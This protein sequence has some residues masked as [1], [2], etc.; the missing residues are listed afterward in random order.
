[1]KQKYFLLF[2]CIPVVSILFGVTSFLS[3]K[4]LTKS[5]FS[6]VAANPKNLIDISKL[7][8]SDYDNIFIEDYGAVFV[9]KNNSPKQIYFDDKQLQSLALSPS[10]QQVAF[11]YDPNETDESKEDELSLMILD[12]VNKSTKEIFHTTFPSWDVTSKPQWLGDKY[13]FFLRHCGTGCQ[14]VT[15]LNIETGQTK[16]AV[17]SYP[18]FPAQQAVTYFE[19]WFGQTYQFKDFV[20]NMHSEMIAGKFY[21][22][23]DLMDKKGME[24]GQKKFLFTGKSLILES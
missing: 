19:D 20:Q 24:S 5:P 17:L 3:Q 11:S 4:S 14:G 13:I 23:F 2:C 6:L 22:I 7:S 16:N 21:L 9:Y 15:L 18:S 1:M 8:R 10:Q 12:L